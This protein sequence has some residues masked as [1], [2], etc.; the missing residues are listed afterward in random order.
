MAIFEELLL[1]AKEH[2][3]DY[4]PQHI[5]DAAI[6]AYNSDPP[7]PPPLASK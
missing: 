7:Q 5:R 1:T 6:M 3:A 2:P 4:P